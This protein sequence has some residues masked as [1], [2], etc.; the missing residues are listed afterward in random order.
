MSLNGWQIGLICYFA[1]NALTAIALIGKT[2]KPM[3][4]AGAVACMLIYGVLV[5]VAVKS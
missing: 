3:T 1:L 2:R 5:W 4:P